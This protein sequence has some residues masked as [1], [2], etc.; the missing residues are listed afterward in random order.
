MIIFIFRKLQYLIQLLYWIPLAC[1]L[2]Q[3]IKCPVNILF[4][5]H[6]SA[7][8]CVNT[9]L[10]VCHVGEIILPGRYLQPLFIQSS[11]EMC[12]ARRRLPLYGAKLACPIKRRHCEPSA[13][14]PASE[15]AQNVPW[16]SEVAEEFV[17]FLMCDNVG[18]VKS[19]PLRR[20]IK[21]HLFTSGFELTFCLVRVIEHT[22]MR[23]TRHSFIKCN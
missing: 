15:V 16:T 21:A 8:V 18:R 23:W 17:K 22:E 2:M 19:E 7:H 5:E 13:F 14:F 3:L 6:L 1:V 12:L 4:A 20:C 11:L 10:T 9:I